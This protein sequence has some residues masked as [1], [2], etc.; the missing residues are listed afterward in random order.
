MEHEED[1]VHKI[2]NLLVVDNSEDFIT[3]FENIKI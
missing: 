3:N 2:I 1:D